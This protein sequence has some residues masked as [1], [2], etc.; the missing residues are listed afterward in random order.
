M[1]FF[2]R[3]KPIAARCPIKNDR[4]HQQ[5]SFTKTESRSY[6]RLNFRRRMGKTKEEVN[7]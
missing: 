5:S 1:I 3:K 4:E 7:T 2:S 6:D